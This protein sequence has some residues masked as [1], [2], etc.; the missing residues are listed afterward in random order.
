MSYARLKLITPN[1]NAV[2][3]NIDGD[4]GLLEEVIA[5]EAAAE[6]LGYTAFTV[7]STPSG[8]PTGVS[9]NAP[10][11]GEVEVSLENAQPGQLAK[12]F[13]SAIIEV[14]PRPD[15]KAEVAFYGADMKPPK[16]DYPYVTNVYQP[17]TWVKKFA[18]IAPF[19]IEHFQTSAQYEVVAE[20]E[21]RYGDNR[22]S[23]GNL[24]RNV[25]SITPV[26]GLA[27]QEITTFEDVA[28][29][30]GVQQEDIPF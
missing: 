19:T 4:D 18:G 30:A 2:D 12:R 8:P 3:L 16:N 6:Q 29:S 10:G 26:A 9:G 23:K 20:V 27:P 22:T 13:R 28:V 17:K 1:G 15:G 25:G 24:Y 5:F 21:V 11:T 14:S 7:A